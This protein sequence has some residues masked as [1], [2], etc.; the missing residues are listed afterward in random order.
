MRR[1]TV[2]LLTAVSLIAVGIWLGPHDGQIN[3]SDGRIRYRKCWIP[4]KVTARPRYSAEIHALGLSN[5]WL[6][7]VTYPLASSN[8][9]DSMCR[10]LLQGAAIW[11]T[12]DPVLGRQMGK[13]IEEYIKA[14]KAQ[15]GLPR[16]SLLCSGIYI[17]YR[18][19]SL[20]GDYKADLDAY[21]SQLT[22]H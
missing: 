6:T 11:G 18:S 3:T 10:N 21:N 17:D 9:S 16:C 20:I 1:V 15:S 8:N 22:S 14:T 7:C 13:D 19:G 12:F 2:A 4:Y 5:H